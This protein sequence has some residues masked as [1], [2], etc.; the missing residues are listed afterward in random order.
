MQAREE[1]GEVSTVDR[2][3]ELV[4]PLVD[5][6]GIELVDVEHGGGL[7]RITL[8]RPGGIDLDA[9]TEASEAIS[10]LLDLHDPVP[11]GRYTL[12]VTSPGL[13]RPLRT[14]AQFRRFVGSR[15][16]VKT[17]AEVPGERRITGVLAEA[18]DDGV[19]VDVTE[20]PGPLGPR[21]LAHG[22]IEW[23]RTVFEWGP[24][25]KPGKRPRRKATPVT[26][27]AATP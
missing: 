27:G 26:E 20:G 4:E 11:G 1:V 12:E 22:D 24:A 18:G 2:V 9:I 15:V 5:A 13:E 7:L 19:T 25:P 23:A 10:A 8:D 21:R 16:K 17:H 6:R 3:R 14:P